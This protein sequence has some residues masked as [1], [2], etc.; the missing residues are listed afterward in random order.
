MVTVIVHCDFGAQEKN[1][2]LLSLFPHL[3]AMKWWDQ[4]FLGDLDGKEYTCNVGDLGS[5]PWLG[6]SPGEENGNPPQYSCLG[7]PM[8]PGAW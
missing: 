7:N 2:L 3:F 5:I 4:G 6:K 8:D 1:L